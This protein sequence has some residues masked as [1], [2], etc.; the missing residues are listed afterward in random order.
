M[1]TPKYNTTTGAASELLTKN[2]I[3]KRLKLCQ[4]KVELMVNDGEIPVI[5]IGSSVRFN[6]QRVLEALENNQINN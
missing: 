5:R 2:A 3:A 6:W 1:N 4:R